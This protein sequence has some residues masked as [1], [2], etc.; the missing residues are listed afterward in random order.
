MKP[1]AG[2]LELEHRSARLTLDPGRG[3]VIREFSWRGEHV[4]R[5]TPADA[6]DDP[7]DVACF[8]MVPFANRVASGRFNFGAQSVQLERNWSEDPHP[9]HGQGWRGPWKLLA[10]STQSATL[11]FE[12]GAN[13]WPWR[14][15]AQQRFQLQDGGLLVE[16]LVENLSATPMPAMLGLHPYFPDA[17]NARLQALLPRVW[18]TDSDMLPKQET[19]TPPQWGFDSGR[20]VAAVPLDN[21]FCG[22]NGTA[23]LFWPGRTVTVHA[24]H[25]NFLHVYA[26]AG[27]EF[28]CIEPQTAAPGALGRNTAEVA[29]LEPGESRAIV[30]QFEIGAS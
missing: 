3:G 19:T 1:R 9:L 27:K 16:L 22:W 11:R 2:F 28:F 6:G 23:R 20:S 12:G 10:V 8:P 14:Y 15:A 17:A 25:C 26:P 21:G 29:A 5:P 18:L 7:F 24:S 30:I 4:L 13:D